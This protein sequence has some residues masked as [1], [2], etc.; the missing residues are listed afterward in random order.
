MKAHCSFWM[1]IAA[2]FFPNEVNCFLF[3]RSITHSRRSTRLM[4]KPNA[5]WQKD[6]WD[7][8]QDDDEYSNFPDYLP[9]PGAPGTG[10]PTS[11][12]ENS[13]M[14]ELPDAHGILF[15]HFQELEYHAV[16]QP[17]RAPFPE[18]GDLLGPYGRWGEPY[19][20]DD[21][22]EEKKRSKRPA[23][24][25]KLGAKSRESNETDD[26]NNDDTADLI[27]DDDLL[28]ST[29]GLSSSLNDD[30]EEED[31]DEDDEIDGDAEI[32][33]DD[34]DDGSDYDDEDD[35]DD[36]VGYEAEGVVV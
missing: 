11:T 10:P 26:D 28:D 25:T 18:W 15:P 22:K 17:H 12:P 6:N 16:L 5:Q 14:E 13:P 32:V 34:D 7:Y 33:L 30:D 1:L 19:D 9:V 4:Y 21:E 2:P 23:T 3:P 8:L 36:N 20:D 29:L 24:K 31:D 35:D 27:G